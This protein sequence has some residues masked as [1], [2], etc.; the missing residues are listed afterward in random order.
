MTDATVRRPIKWSSCADTNVGMVRKINE[1]SVLARPD[2]GLW[3]VADGMGGYEAGDVA[4]NM[5]VKTLQETQVKEHLND[6]VNQIE[7]SLIDVNQRILEYA[8]IMLDGRTLGSTAVSL[9]IKGHVGACLWVGDSRLYRYRNNALL[10]LSRDH[11]HVEELIQKGLINAEEAENHPQSNVIT[12]AVGAFSDVCVDLNVFS[13]QMGD[14]FLL[15]SDGLYNAV[16]Q[17]DIITIL[18]KSEPQ[19]IVDNLISKALDNGAADN[20]SV[21]IV[22]GEPGSISTIN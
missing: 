11:S 18:S 2:L 15:C 13:V 22:K 9:L 4:S 21:I 8:D 3:V 10:Q 17:H 6:F 7:D 14:L 5:I 16:P 19:N 12:R 1:D 20:V